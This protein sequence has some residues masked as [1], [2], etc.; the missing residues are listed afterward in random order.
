MGM[1]KDKNN[2]PSYM[3][4]LKKRKIYLLEIR[5]QDLNG[6]Q[7]KQMNKIFS[8]SQTLV[9]DFT[10]FFIDEYSN[11]SNNFKIVDVRNSI[12]DYKK[13]KREGDGIKGESINHGIFSKG[14]KIYDTTVNNNTARKI[15][16]N[17]TFYVRF[18]SD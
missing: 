1:K 12:Y 8:N 15:N 4:N 16:G 17:C 2:N 18:F 13:L 6:S 11:D 14:A 5:L 7:I 10:G 9:P 3:T